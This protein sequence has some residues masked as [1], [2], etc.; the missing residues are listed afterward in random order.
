MISPIVLTIYGALYTIFPATLV[1][2]PYSLTSPIV[3]VPL[4]FIVIYVS[5]GKNVHLVFCTGGGGAVLCP[6]CFSSLHRLNSLPPSDFNAE[7]IASPWNRFPSLIC[8]LYH[9]SP[10]LSLVVALLV[11]ALLCYSLLPVVYRI[12]CISLVAYLRPLGVGVRPM[13]L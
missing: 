12:H 5:P 1:T 9:L 2:S 3:W 11:I 8:L 10:M 4:L 13:D 6:L 7:A